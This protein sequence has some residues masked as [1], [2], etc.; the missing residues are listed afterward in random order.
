MKLIYCRECQDV[1][2]LAFVHRFCECGK[3]WGAYVNDLDA[4]YWG[5]AVPIEFN[6]NTLATAVRSQPERGLGFVF[7][8]FVI[9]KECPSMIKKR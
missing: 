6:N 2:K 8:A 3:S 9:P 1:F 7:E 4:E 5:P